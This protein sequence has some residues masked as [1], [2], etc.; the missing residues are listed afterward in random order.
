MFIFL[1]SLLFLMAFVQTSFADDS[2]LYQIELIVFK[3]NHVQMPDISQWQ[4]YQP[5][6]NQNMIEL[7]NQQSVWPSNQPTTY[8][9]LPK[10]NWLLKREDNI[11]SRSDRY[12]ILLHWAWLQDLSNPT[13]IKP[14]HIYGGTQF[15]SNNQYWQINGT[16]NVTQSNYIN[17]KAHLNFC[18]PDN[19]TFKCLPLNESRKMKPDQ[20]NYLDGPVFGLLVK[21]HPEEKIK[22][23]P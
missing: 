1:P 12:T 19:D 4:N 11:L 7:Q 18:L 5:I 22:A 10:N 17:F 14:I 13:T 15:D 9:L 21:V 23:K 3:L 2:G 20:L 6:S 16:V 8:Q